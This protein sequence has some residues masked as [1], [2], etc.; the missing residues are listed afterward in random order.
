MADNDKYFHD[1]AKQQ[2]IEARHNQAVQ[3]VTL[4]YEANKDQGKTGK[5]GFGFIAISNK[6][7]ATMLDYPDDLPLRPTTLHG[8]IKTHPGDGNYAG[9]WRERG[10]DC[11]DLPSP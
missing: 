5:K 10:R 3:L 1:Q 2:L 11:Q 6:Y 7:N 8:Y 4:E 9:F